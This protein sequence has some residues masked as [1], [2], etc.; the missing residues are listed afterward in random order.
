[1]LED[2]AYFREIGENIAKA[3]KAAGLTQVDLARRLN[4]TRGSVAKFELGT[5]RPPLHTLTHVA[6]VLGVTH[7]SLLPRQYQAATTITTVALAPVNAKELNEL[8]D[9]INAAERSI[10]RIKRAQSR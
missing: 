2:R 8:Q 10:K 7:D 4:L 6:V 5:Q 9:L 3:R 1:M